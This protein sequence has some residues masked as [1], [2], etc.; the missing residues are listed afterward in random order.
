M[1]KYRTWSV[2]KRVAALSVVL[3]AISVA[4]GFVGATSTRTLLA[5][6]NGVSTKSLPGI[7]HIA[8]IQALGLEF[9]GT[10]LLMGTPG[11]KD[12]YKTKQLA[13]LKEL[14]TQIQAQLE[15]YKQS[16]SPHERVRY[17]KL[18]T[19]TAK[20]VG[21]IQHFLDLTLSGKTEDA[22]A[23]WSTSGGAV[24]KAFRKAL[25]EEVQS[26]ERMTDRFLESGLTA[27]HWA[28]VLSWSLLGIAVLMGAMLGTFTVR[29][30]TRVLTVVAEHL[31]LTAEQVSNAS[32]QVASASQ[33]LAGNSTEQAAALEQTSTSGQEVT[34]MIRRNAE[35]CES[36]ATLMVV[37]ETTLAETNRKLDETLASMKEITNS[38]ERI[39]SIIKVVDG[40]AFQTNIL[41]LNAAVEAARAGEAGMGF[42]V[43]ADEVRNL[44]GRCSG[45]AKDISTSIAESVENARTG[46]SRLDE[47]A[48][49]ARNMAVSAMKAK[50]LVQEINGGARQ[51]RA[52]IDQIAQALIHMETTTQQTAAIA[53]E[54]ASASEQLRAQAKSM[55][56][57][58][59]SLEALV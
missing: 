25:D 9:R 26:N 27:A 39:A 11:L 50:D 43:V 19:A 8:A 31:R 35:S 55:E 40:I 2:G 14:Q 15:Q 16:V 49:S 7:K 58:V 6:L 53:E 41:A 30:I 32:N 4:L 56:D 24:S 33:V 38:S 12:D 59:A 5:G 42:A 28:T 48:A 47:A 23:F 17:D 51:Q 34:A 44:A 22:G 37:T 18:Q 45:A 46:K 3:I 1:A 10:S 13:H 54:S 21:A 57:L 52:G 20:F 29:N 36:A